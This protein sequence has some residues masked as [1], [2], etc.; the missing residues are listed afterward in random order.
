MAMVEL[1]K[2]YLY[3]GA[4]DYAAIFITRLVVLAQKTFDHAMVGE[5]VEDLDTLI[6]A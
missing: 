5:E 6:D 4:G 3:N 1:L 2:P